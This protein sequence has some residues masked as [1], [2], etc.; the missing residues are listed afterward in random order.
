[1][2]RKQQERFSALLEVEML[3]RL[4]SSGALQAAIVN[5][6]AV[7]VPSRDSLRWEEDAGKYGHRD[8]D[9]YTKGD[10]KD[11]LNDDK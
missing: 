8:H 2:F 9:E 10:A 3:S 11:I 7:E 4:L 6:K 1:M 5:S